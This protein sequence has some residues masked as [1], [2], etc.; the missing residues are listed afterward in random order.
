[1]PELMHHSFP[2][3]FR[4]EV[5]PGAL[6]AMRGIAQI[7]P[8]G[9][10]LYLVGGAL[11][12]AEY[13]ESHGVGLPQRD[14]DFLYVG[15]GREMF[16][17]QL[18]QI[19]FRPGAIQ[20]PS[21]RSFEKPC[22]ANPRSLDEYIVLDIGYWESGE[23]DTLLAEKINF[24]INGWAIDIQYAVREDWRNHILALPHAHE[25]IAS[26]QLRLNPAQSPSI[27]YSNIFAA[28]RF[29]SQGFKVPS[30]D[31]VQQML[32]SFREI[33]EDKLAPNVKKLVSY[34][35]SDAKA[36][37]LLAQLGITENIF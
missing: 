30:D 28:A 9:A 35:G 15:S 11:R 18:L 24:S 4:D 17:E 23:I 2:H 27:A 3:C 1:M 19:G 22:N 32:Q 29:M 5:R 16:D 7:V 25:D 20:R 10:R 34:V 26:K 13:Y 37:D 12:N 36:R 21:Q 14:Y 31:E 6:E 8:K 33:P